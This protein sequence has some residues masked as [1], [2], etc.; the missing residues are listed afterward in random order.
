MSTYRFPHK[1]IL[2]WSSIQ[3]VNPASI[4]NP[5]HPVPKFYCPMKQH[6]YRVLHLMFSLKHTTDSMKDNWMKIMWHNSVNSCKLV[7]IFSR[8]IFN[9][10]FWIF[11]FHSRIFYKS[12]VSWSTIN[13]L[14]V[15]LIQNTL[16]CTNTSEGNAFYFEHPLKLFLV[17]QSLWYLTILVNGT[18]QWVSF[19]KQ[20]LNFPEVFHF[21]VI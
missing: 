14:H 7:I 13:I 16:N 11:W 8:S 10:M 18:F 20:T 9:V 1:L 17:L 15:V 3:C 12:Q 5:Y 2:Y 4:I 19:K 21:Q 6:G